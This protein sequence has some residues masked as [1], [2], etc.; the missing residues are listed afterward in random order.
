MRFGRGSPFVA[1]KRLGRVVCIITAIFLLA[2]GTHAWWSIRA[3]KKSEDASATAQISS[4][5][6]LLAKTS[7]TYINDGE[8]T[9]L[10]QSIVEASIRFH[11]SVCRVSFSPSRI[12]AD[13]N[14]ARITLSNL[15]STQQHH[16]EKNRKNR[17]RRNNP[18]ISCESEII[19]HGNARAGGNTDDRDNNRS[20]N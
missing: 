4:I 10:R 2:M 19:A 8:L 11:L 5:G 15:T 12:L 18:T 7:E 17:S 1:S 14:P 6:P 3:D 13:K 16:P 9:A 20:R